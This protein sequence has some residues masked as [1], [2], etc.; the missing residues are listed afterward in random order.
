MSNPI[1]M[2]HVLHVLKIVNVQKFKLQK[3]WII[4]SQRYENEVNKN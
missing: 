4:T 3:S 1:D 2:Y